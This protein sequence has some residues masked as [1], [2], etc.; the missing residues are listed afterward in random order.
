MA[1]I[2]RF[3]EC[4]SGSFV[5]NRHAEDDKNEPSVLGETKR[6]DENPKEGIKVEM[7]GREKPETESKTLKVVERTT[8]IRARS[9]KKALRE[10]QWFGL[11]IIAKSSGNGQKKLKVKAAKRVVNGMLVIL[12]Y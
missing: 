8:K 4:N 5:E 12:R 7:Q 6:S 9:H 11:G 2:R 10:S 1:L 3:G